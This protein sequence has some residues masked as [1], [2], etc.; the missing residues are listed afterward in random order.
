MTG[1][2]G[3]HKFNINFKVGNG[4]CW[5][6]PNTIAETSLFEEEKQLS[7]SQVFSQKSG[8]EYKTQAHNAT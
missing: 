7:L 8:N 6:F 2:F 5:D 4:S 3:S 1:C